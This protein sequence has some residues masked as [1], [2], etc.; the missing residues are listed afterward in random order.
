M[1]TK[2]VV[3]TGMSINTPLGDNLDVYIDKL[4]AGTSAITKWESLDSEKIYCKVGGDIKDYDVKA[5]IKSYEGRI[6]D[7]TYKRILKMISRFPSHMGI[8]IQVAVDAFID[9]GLIDKINEEDNDIATVVAGHNLNQQYTFD[10]H[11]AFDEE[12]DF[13]EGLFALKALDTNHVGIVSEALQ[14]RGPGYT[15]GG[16]CASGNMALRC[17]VDEI[18]GHGLSVAAV[19]A[20]ILSFSP[21]DLQGM[22]VMG[23]ISY[24]SFNETPEVASRPYD[25]AREGFIP[26]HGAATIIVEDL[27]H[28]LER[29]AK[30]YAEILGVENSAD[31]S[32]LPKP[33]REGQAT[34]MKRLLKVCNVKPEEVDYVSAHATS[35]PLGDLTEVAD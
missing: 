17:A 21:L 2:R 22:A 13:I 9:A 4:I 11:E 28:A 35:T 6:P 24:K 33:S 12:P 1:S 30:I 20:P 25:M 5:K 10:N 31:G 27:D 16:A 19:V 7:V 23:A 26:S 3:I 15:V 8:S 18:R 14:L 32:H 34:L 29:G